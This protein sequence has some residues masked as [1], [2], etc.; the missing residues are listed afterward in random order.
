MLSEKLPSPRELTSAIWAGDNAY[1]F[2]GGYNFNAIS[3]IVRFDPKG[4]DRMNSSLGLYQSF[5]ILIVIMVI[6]TLIV[7]DLRLD[8]K[9]N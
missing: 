8:K 5:L 6:I 9:R 7:F 1:V 3:E 2:G 4:G